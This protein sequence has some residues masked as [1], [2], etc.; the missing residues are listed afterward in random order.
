M[1]FTQVS[2][3]EAKIK[4]EYLDPIGL[5]LDSNRSRAIA[6]KI[7]SLGSE[8]KIEVY[9]RSILAQL[10]NVKNVAV[11]EVSFEGIIH[12][13]QIL[14]DF[15]DELLSD[16]WDIEYDKLNYPPGVIKSIQKSFTYDKIVKYA[17]SEA[18][19]PQNSEDTL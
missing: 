5:S 9:L 7:L 3:L 12:F 14:N 16:R 19:I 6:E 2:S 15:V 1:T 17:A 18:K 10:N 13:Q 8:D 11:R 4:R